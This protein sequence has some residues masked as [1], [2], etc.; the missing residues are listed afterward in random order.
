MDIILKLKNRFTK[1]SKRFTTSSKYVNIN[2]EESKQMLE[3]QAI[4]DTNGYKVLMH[5]LQTLSDEI[6]DV[7]VLA[8]NYGNKRIDEQIGVLGGAGL[9]ASH[10][11]QTFIEKY[12][13]I[14]EEIIEENK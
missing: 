14:E 8:A 5:D 12:E 9:I 4:Q 10:I 13:N 3:V 7:S 2:I 1:L 11:I 6:R